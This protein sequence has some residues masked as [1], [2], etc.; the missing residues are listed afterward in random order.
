MFT[1][2]QYA[3][4]DF[5]RGRKLERFGA[6]VLDRPSPAAEGESRAVPETWREATAR[7]EREEAE[8]GVWEAAAELPP[9]WTIQHGTLVFELRRTEFGHVG[10][11]PE[12]APNWDWIGHVVNAAQRPL[13]ILN[14]F[15]YTGGSTL[16]AAAAGAEVVHIDAA[17]NVVQWARRNAELSGLAE[18]PIRWIAEDAAKFVTREVKRGNQYDAV[19][20]DPPSYGHGARGEV[21]KLAEHLPALLSDCGR[22]TQ[23]RQA[24]ILLSCHTPGYGPRELRDLLLECI[25]PG[26]VETQPLDLLDS[27]GRALDSGISARWLPA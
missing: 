23:Q 7:Y 22:L 21:W 6:Y 18:R 5:G 19:I 16:A 14:L 3:L 12:Q 9:K 1:P 10:L 11:F 26:R 27:S 15:A 24:F 8:R 4:L 17:K 20:L 25:G 13:K 2:D